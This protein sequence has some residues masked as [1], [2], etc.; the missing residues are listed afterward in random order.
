[1]QGSKQ[2]ERLV[3]RIGLYPPFAIQPLKSRKPN[4][5][6]TLC[7]QLG[8]NLGFSK[9]AVLPWDRLDKRS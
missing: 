9:R 1:M 5:V 7:I 4:A 2:T 3:T 8:P 6:A